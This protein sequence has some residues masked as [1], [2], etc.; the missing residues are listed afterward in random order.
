MSGLIFVGGIITG[1]LWLDDGKK[2]SRN[3]RQGNRV[4]DSE[5]IATALSANSVGG[6]GGETSLY[7]V[8]TNKRKEDENLECLA[9]KGDLLT[10]RNPQRQKGISE[11]VM[12]TL[13]Q[14]VTHGVIEVQTDTKENK[15]KE[16]E[17]LTN[18]QTTIF[19]YL[20]NEKT[21]EQKPFKYISLFAGIGGFDFGLNA[22]GGECVFASEIDKF[23]KQA[24]TTLHGLEPHGDITKIDAK[25]IPDHDVIAAGFPC[26]SFSVAGKRGGFEDA[27][28]TLFFEVAR[29]ASEKQPKVLLL[30]NVKGL[31]GH[32]K[33]KTLDTIVKTLNEIGY[34]VDFEVLNSKYFG[35]PQNRE[36]IF[37]VAIR[38]DLVANEPWKIEG[39]TVV[40]KGKRRI[41]G[42]EDVKTFNFNWPTNDTVEKR[43]VDVL[44]SDVDEKFYLSEEKTSKLVAK[45]EDADSYETRIIDPSN[46]GRE[47]ALREYAEVSPTLTSRDY[48][49]PRL[50]GHREPK[51]IETTGIN[52]SKQ[53]TEVKNITDVS[54]TLMARDYK[55]FGN[56]EMT[57][58]VE[59]LPIREATKK[60]FAVAYE[61]D[62]VNISFPSSNTR[63]GRVGKD[64]QAQTLEASGVNQGVV[65][66]AIGASRGR[67]IENPSDRTPGKDV[68]QRL[69]INSEGT[70]NTLTSVQ[71]DNYVV[72]PPLRIRK[73][74]PLEC[75]RLQ[76]FTDEQHNAVEASGISNSQRY[77]QAGN[78][79]TVNVIEAIGTRLLPYL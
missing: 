74:T 79:V 31:V 36:R 28:G 77:K 9:I 38:E 8:N 6:L 10:R 16:D 60:G 55:G 52:L 69:E 66:P 4:Y 39:N 58:V 59:G 73:L 19:E 61:G 50:V 35:V 27:R 75:W 7:L 42:Y 21:T 26:Q 32:D 3:F 45:L 48:K 24:Y 54:G 44:E 12:F 22:V 30:E 68:E 41:S 65:L 63:R 25:D 37:I 5:G 62:A 70:S 18:K 13:R 29:I 40:P 1:N 46:S 2:N 33:G 43:L 56:Q 11:E 76:G 23:A 20:D 17:N 78:A 67:N 64:G 49:D 15:R 53:A 72:E 47:S 34:R 51:N 14:A 71:K 57:G